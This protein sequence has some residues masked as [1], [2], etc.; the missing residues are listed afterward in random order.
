MYSTTI[1]QSIIKQVKLD[2]KRDLREMPKATKSPAFMDP[3]RIAKS[4]TIT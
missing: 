3:F 1:N 4:V 2:S